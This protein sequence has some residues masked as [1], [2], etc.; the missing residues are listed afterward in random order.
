MGDMSG[1]AVPVFKFVTDINALTEKNPCSQSGTA[2]QNKRTSA[3]PGRFQFPVMSRQA[4]CSFHEEPIFKSVVPGKTAID[5]IG[6]AVGVHMNAD[7]WIGV[8]KEIG[9]IC[10]GCAK[11]QLCVD[12]DAISA[13]WLTFNCDFSIALFALVMPPSNTLKFKSR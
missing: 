13:C 7:E 3:V 11:D 5:E 8:E 4:K 6:V 12:S 1:D 2:I 10:N 9:K